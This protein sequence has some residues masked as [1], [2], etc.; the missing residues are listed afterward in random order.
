MLTQEQRDA[1]AAPFPAE[2]VG[3]KPIII[4]RDCELRECVEIDHRPE[5][6]ET[7]HQIITPAHEHHQFVG[8]AD[9]TAR[10]FEVDP[11]WDYEPMGHDANG[12]PLFDEYGGLWI[13]LIVGGERR[14]GYGHADG[15]KGGD[16]VLVA[17]GHAIRIAAARGFQVALYLWKPSGQTRTAR[18]PAGEE[19]TT[20]TVE[21][22]AKQLQKDIQKL[23]HRKNRKFIHVLREFDTWSNGKAD[24]STADPVVLR[25]FMQ[26]LEKT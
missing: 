10:L 23:G 14:K 8:H 24:W 11:K 25:G 22:T 4:C 6:C 21:R 26:H 2:A 9:V 7:C 13:W 1:L 19:L 3:H 18:E 15:R 16:A 17:I 12:L 20:N 5:L